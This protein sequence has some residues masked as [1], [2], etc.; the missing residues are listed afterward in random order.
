MINLFGHV[1]VLV[2]NLNRTQSRYK[3]RLDIV[4]E[5]ARILELP[6]GMQQRVNYYYDYV[7]ERTRCLDRDVFLKD[8]SGPLSAE[9]S[10][11]C[12]R[13][14]IAKVPEFNGADGSLFPPALFIM[15][16][17]ICICSVL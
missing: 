14:L 5:N 15:I 17:D 11:H 3:D 7:W 1:F 16:I 8:L 10:L 12:H 13:H 2:E 4:N 6:P 9:I